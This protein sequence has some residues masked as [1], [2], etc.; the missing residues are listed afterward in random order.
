MIKKMANLEGV[1]LTF[2][3]RIFPFQV[4]SGACYITGQWGRAQNKIKEI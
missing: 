2:P 1:H 4:K 3:P